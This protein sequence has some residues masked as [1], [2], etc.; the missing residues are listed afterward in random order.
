MNFRVP[1]ETE[2]WGL[3]ERLPASQGLCFWELVALSLM[4]RILGSEH[5]NSAEDCGVVG[6]N[7]MCFVEKLTFRKNTSPPPSGSKNGLSKKA[8]GVGGNLSSG[9]KAFLLPTCIRTMTE[10]LC[11]SYL[12]DITPCSLLKGSRRFG[13]K[14]RL[15]F[16]GGRIRQATNYHG[17]ESKLRC[18]FLAC[19]IRSSETS[20]HFQRTTWPHTQK[21]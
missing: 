14:C 7:T 11:C 5:C 21:T 20:V 8:V 6:G 1:L 16:Q 4:L 12:L 3:A 2:V 18:W 15:S 19:L 13:G 17:A 9:G 10:I